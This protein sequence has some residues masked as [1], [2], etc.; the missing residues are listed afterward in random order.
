MQIVSNGDSL[1]EIS[2]TVFWK[3]YE[4][5]FK[6]SSTENVTQSAKP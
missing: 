5:Y 6:L 2:K 4:K 1:H 3:K